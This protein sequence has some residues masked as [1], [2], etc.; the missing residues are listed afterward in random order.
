MNCDYCKLCGHADIWHIM[1]GQ[2]FCQY[3]EDSEEVKFENKPCWCRDFTTDYKIA[4]K[5]Y[6]EK[7]KKELEK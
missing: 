7:Y 4:E 3:V 2:C 1:S 5:L 6:N